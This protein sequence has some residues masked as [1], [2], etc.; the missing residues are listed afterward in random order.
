MTAAIEV[1]APSRL[2]F[3]LLSF[4]DT[5]TRQYGGAGVMIERPGLRL[6]VSQAH[7]F[8]SAGPLAVRARAVVER[9]AALANV[10]QLPRAHVEV[11]EAPAEHLGLGTGTQLA[12]AVVAA[13]HA[14]GGGQVLVPSALATLAGRG[15]RSAIGTYGFCHGGLL[16]EVGKLPNQLLAP[17]ERRLAVPSAWRFVLVQA[18]VARGLSGDAER[19]AFDE[20]PPVPRAT[21]VR[22]LDEL[23]GE[24][25]PAVEQADFA[26]FAASL[27]RYGHLAGMCFAPKQ[28]GPF[29]SERIATV[30]ERIRALGAEGVGQS[31]WGPTVFVVQPSAEAAEKLVEQIHSLVDP[32]LNVVIAKPNNSGA[33]LAEVEGP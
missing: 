9:W 12:L 23:A 33:R 13:I 14:L 11:L 3:G 21:T 19:G 5:G 26:R 7:E 25:L 4:G 16:V 6:R 32:A 15:A 17:L 1:F 2:H 18:D 24:L 27:Y 28:G 29:A 10:P 20:L 31:S 8:S 30:V 22:L